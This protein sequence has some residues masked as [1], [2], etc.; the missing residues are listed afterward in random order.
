[1][2][3]WDAGTQAWLTKLE[4]FCLVTLGLG[5]AQRRYATALHRAGRLCCF[6][7][8]TYMRLLVQQLQYIHVRRQTGHL[9]GALK[10]ISGACCSEQSECAVEYSD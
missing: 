9:A 3:R 6:I 7:L 4:S 10:L 8:V 1:M 2:N 5:L